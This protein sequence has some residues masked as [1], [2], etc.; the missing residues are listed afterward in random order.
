MLDLFAEMPKEERGHPRIAPGK[1]R[2]AIIE[3]HLEE[4]REDRLHLTE[5]SLAALPLAQLGADVI[6]VEAL[7][8]DLVRGAGPNRS[9]IT[10]TFLS[11]NRSK[12]SLALDLKTEAGSKI[13]RELI[14]TADVLR[15]DPESADEMQRGIVDAVLDRYLPR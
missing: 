10:A 5:L 12:R 14:A 9:G 1:K 7:S 3:D 15:L 2:G 11:S 6:K 4:G 13:L 8:R